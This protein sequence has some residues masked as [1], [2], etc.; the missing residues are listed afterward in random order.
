MGMNIKAMEF[1]DNGKMVKAK[2]ICTKSNIFFSMITDKVIYWA[3]LELDYAG[4]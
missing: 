4:G 1:D 2:G 3:E